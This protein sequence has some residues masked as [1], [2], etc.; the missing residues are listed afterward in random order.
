MKTIW[1]SL[2]Q[3]LTLHKIQIETYGGSQGIRDIGLV[4]SA[5]YSA[6]QTFDGLDLYPRLSDKAAALWH[7]FVSNHAFVDGNKRIGLNVA[8]VFLRMNGYKLDLTAPQVEAITLR[9]A[10]GEMSRQELLDNLYVHVVA[11]RKP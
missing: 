3:V 9:I 10:T 8:V 6:Q 5:L 1:L 4:E 11:L 2:E 7:S